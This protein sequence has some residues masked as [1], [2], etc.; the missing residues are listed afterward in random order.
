MEE[1]LED[2]IAAQQHNQENS[3]SGISDADAGD[4]MLEVQPDIVE[5]AAAATAN[6]TSQGST[7]SIK[8]PETAKA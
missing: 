8:E 2:H 6:N 1:T 7:T 3:N 4:E 5:E